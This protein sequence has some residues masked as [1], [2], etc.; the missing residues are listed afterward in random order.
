MDV[1]GSSSA[2]NSL[3]TTYSIRTGRKDPKTRSS[4]ETFVSV[5]TFEE[6][7]Y[8]C[9]CYITRFP[10]LPYDYSPGATHTFSGGRL[11]SRTLDLSVVRN[12][13][14]QGCPTTKP[15]NATLPWVLVLSSQGFVRMGCLWNVS[16]GLLSI[17]RQNS[18]ET[19][20]HCSDNVDPASSRCSGCT[21]FH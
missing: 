2:W 3:V 16:V 13:I 7:I 10:D 5:Q 14:L 8:P 1:E 12:G 6:A 20:V 11:V 15:S 4:F 17:G 21:N 19:T 9:T 18:L